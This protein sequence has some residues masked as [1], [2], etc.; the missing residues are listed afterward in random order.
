MEGR[1]SGN[2]QQATS[3]T[4]RQHSPMTARSTSARATATS[5]PSGH[6]RTQRTFMRIPRCTLPIVARLGAAAVL[7]LAV[8]GLAAAQLSDTAVWPMLHRDLDHAG[9]SPLLGPLFPSGAP[10]PVTDVLKWNGVAQVKSSPSIGG[11]GTIYAAVGWSLCAINPT[12]MSTRWCRRLSGDVSPSSPAI[13]AD[14]T[15]YVG[16]RGN[17]MNAVVDTTLPDGTRTGVI[18][19]KYADGLEGD[20]KTSP[21]IGPDGT[22]YFAFSQNHHGFGVVTALN[23]DGTFKWDFTIGQS[24]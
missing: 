14:G 11:D 13:A 9:Q 3:S 8:P 20:I 5:T 12:D 7:M 10:D 19:W 15:I 24:V 21:A 17:T 22:I 2:S 18:K 6:E 23:P 4:R 16:D 1:R